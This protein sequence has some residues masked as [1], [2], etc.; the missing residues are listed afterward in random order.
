MPH[1][2][3]YVQSVILTASLV[4]EYFT[5]QNTSVE[6][7]VTEVVGYIQKYKKVQRRYLKHIDFTVKIKEPRYLLFELAHSKLLGEC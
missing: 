6:F 7:S 1:C 3:E 5:L 2:A 4:Q